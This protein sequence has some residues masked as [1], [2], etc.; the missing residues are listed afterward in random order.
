MR[1]VFDVLVQRL[2]EGQHA[3]EGAQT[4]ITSIKSWVAKEISRGRVAAVVAAIVV[5]LHFM[6]FEEVNSGVAVNVGCVA[7]TRFSTAMS[8]PTGMLVGFMNFEGC[9]LT[10]RGWA[11]SPQEIWSPKNPASFQ[12]RR[13]MILGVSTRLQ[14][15]PPSSLAAV[16]TS[17]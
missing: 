3:V 7:E 13:T 6:D 2:F 14:P 11:E 12:Q 17:V 16:E 10:K 1:P 4:T 15:G 9:L 5:A 8:F